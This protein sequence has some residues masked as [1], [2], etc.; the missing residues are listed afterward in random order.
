[1]PTFRDQGIILARSASGEA[2]KVFYIYSRQHGK[3]IAIAK[4]SRKIKSKLAGHLEP[5]MLSDLLIAR[6]KKM[7]R[8]AG[9]DLIKSRVSLRE[10]LPSLS[11]ACYFLELTDSLCQPEEPE[12]RIFE[13]LNLVLDEIDSR[14]EQDK[15]TKESFLKL[16]IWYKVKILDI[17]G[18]S[19]D[20]ESLSIDDR[21][22][23]VFK[24]IR[25]K[26]EICD[27]LK[28]KVALKELLEWNKL[29]SEVVNYHLEKELKSEKFLAK[30]LVEK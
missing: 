23:L 10:S 14:I 3:L 12:L 25:E 19:V 16:L 17:L 27:F 28:A 2:D 13:H 5:A 7:D 20:R 21:S 24:K 9:A 8:L 4:G 18:L 26:K 11:L 15:I 30:F 6:G 29:I 22:R 1:M